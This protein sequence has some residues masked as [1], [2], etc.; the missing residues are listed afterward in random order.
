ML[1]FLQSNDGTLSRKL[2][3]INLETGSQALLANPPG[4]GV[5]EANLSMAEKLQRERLRDRNLGV[6]R[7][8]WSAQGNKLLVPLPD[9]IYVQ[10]GAAGQLRLVVPSS[11]GT[12]ILDPQLSRAPLPHLPAPWVPLTPSAAV[13][14]RS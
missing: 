11:F 9:G 7:F 3:C 2:Y 6:T 4:G 13:R 5:S 1:T 14:V 10:D 12:G 8:S